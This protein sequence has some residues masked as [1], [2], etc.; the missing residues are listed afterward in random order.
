[1]D[2]V[3]FWQN[4]DPNLLPMT[5][6]NFTTSSSRSQQKVYENVY[7]F[8]ENPEKVFITSYS[9]GAENAQIDKKL[10]N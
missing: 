2:L 3:R 4:P 5:T 8:A 6:E 10:L 9:F 1:M 7:I